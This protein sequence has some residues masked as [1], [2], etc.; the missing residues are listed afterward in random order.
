MKCP[1]CGAET[2]A[3][4]FCSYCG[5]ELPQPNNS[6]TTTN[7]YN[8]SE[9]NTYHV[10][11]VYYI[12]QDPNQMLNHPQ[13]PQSNPGAYQVRYQAP[14]QAPYVY[15]SMISSK[16]KDLTFIL[17]LLFGVLGVHRFYAGKIGTGILYL[18]TGG[19]F[20]IGSFI[21]LISISSNSFKDSDNLPIKG[22]LVW[23]RRILAFYLFVVSM[24]AFSDS[25]SGTTGA[26][27]IMLILSVVIFIRS[28]KKSK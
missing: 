13:L 18:F 19:L 11:N 10:T 27:L 15:Q 8:N 3:G 9:A 7:T 20:G 14:V 21:D 6:I 25:D 1:N 5:S 17:C 26:A 22:T 4:R 23:G 28:F 24:A 16:N 2:S 12:N